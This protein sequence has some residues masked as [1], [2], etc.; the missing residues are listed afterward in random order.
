VEAPGLVLVF[1]AVDLLDA[2]GQLQRLLPA[3]QLRAA[4]LHRL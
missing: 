3:E 2:A 4:S 1:S